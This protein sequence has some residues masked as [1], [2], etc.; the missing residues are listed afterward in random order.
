VKNLQKENQ[1]LILLAAARMAAIFGGRLP[2]LSMIG[3]QKIDQYI[4]ATIFI[5]DI[6]LNL[7]LIPLWGING[8]AAATMITSVIWT[9]LIVVY[10]KKALGINALYIPFSEKIR[11]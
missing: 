9:I 1:T 6:A 3:K 4:A 5:I 8:A 7:V 2:I 11:N 10:L